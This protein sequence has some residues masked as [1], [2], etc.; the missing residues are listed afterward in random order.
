MNDFNN[1]KTQFILPCPELTE[2][3]A[4]VEKDAMIVRSSAPTRT[5]IACC[6]TTTWPAPGPP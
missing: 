4:D 3:N 2:T 5:R 1:F 6:A